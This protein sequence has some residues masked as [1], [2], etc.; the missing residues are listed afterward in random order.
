MP[1]EKVYDS[2]GLYDIEIGWGVDQEVQVGI[3]THTGVSIAEMLAERPLDTGQG[4]V[5]AALARFTGL[6]GTLDRRQINRLIKMLRK[7]RDEA[8]GRDE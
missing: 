8:Y 6:W 2:T 7:A 5:E 4:G 1:K 3:E